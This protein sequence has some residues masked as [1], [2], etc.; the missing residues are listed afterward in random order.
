MKSLRTASNSSG[1]VGT[2]STSGHPSRGRCPFRGRS[3]PLGAHG[4]DITRREGRTHRAARVRRACPLRRLRLREEVDHRIGG[5]RGVRSFCLLR[6]SVR[7]PVTRGV[8]IPPPRR[9]PHRIEHPQISGLPGGPTVRHLRRGWISPRVRDRDEEGRKRVPEGAQPATGPA[10]LTRSGPRGVL[11]ERR[12]AIRPSRASSCGA[13]GR[14]RLPLVG[15]PRVSRGSRRR[16]SSR[17]SRR[18]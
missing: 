8:A 5:R 1:E 14:P 16:S 9:C 17:S 3:A 7:V 2:G 15:R 13:R 6:A 10:A 11:R 4:Y 18:G 12:R